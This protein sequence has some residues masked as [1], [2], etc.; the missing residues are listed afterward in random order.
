MRG[1][2]KRAGCT[3]TYQNYYDIVPPMEKSQGAERKEDNAKKA[4]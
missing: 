1:V 3:L 2:V 4:V